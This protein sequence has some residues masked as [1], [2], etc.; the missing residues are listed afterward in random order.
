MID[1]AVTVQKPQIVVLRERLEARRDELKAALL[2]IPVDHFIRAFITAATITPDIQACS[3]QSIWISLMRACRDRLLPDGKQGAI[4]PF[5]GTATWIPMYAGLILRFQ[6]SGQFQWIGANVVRE[7]E[8]FDYYIDETGPHYRHVPG[9]NSDAPI[10]M[11][12]AAATTKDGG[13]FIEPMTIGE[14]NKIKNM[15]KATREDAPW[16][17]W[18]AEMAKKTA[19]RRLS[20][21]LPVDS[22]ISDEDLPELE[23]PAV[24]PIADRASPVVQPRVTVPAGEGEGE[25]GPPPIDANAAHVASDGDPAAPVATI[26]DT[27]RVAYERGKRWRAAKNDKKGIPPEYRDANRTREALAWQAG[28]DGHSMPEWKD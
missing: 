16:R 23:A 3:W 26:D 20:K 4:V 19:L 2:D 10:V 9:N 6:R 11:V 8:P 24:A 27:I 7:G 18:F 13:R 14:I 12:Y 21:M 25:Q 22:G 5:K 1:T 28:Y 15:S 17:M